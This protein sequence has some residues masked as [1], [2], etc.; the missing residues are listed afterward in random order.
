VLGVV[1]VVLDRRGSIG[2]VLLGVDRAPRFDRPVDD[3]GDALSKT[4]KAQVCDL[5]F[6]VVAGAGFEPATFGL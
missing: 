3:A 4:S 5:G 6:H 2:N 1:R